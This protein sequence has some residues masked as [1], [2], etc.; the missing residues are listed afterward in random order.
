[1]TDKR[2]IS[3]LELHP[4]RFSAAI[5]KIK[6]TYLLACPCGEMK[7]SEANIERQ[8]EQPCTRAGCHGKFTWSY[9]QTAKVAG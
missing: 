1:M 3:P 5:D 2:T 7:N 6:T 9:A 8:K 4:A